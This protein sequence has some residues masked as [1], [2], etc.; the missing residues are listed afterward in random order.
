MG[1][2]FFI[3]GLVVGS[4]LNCV[5]YRMERSQGFLFGRSFCPHCK[6]EL[7]FFDLIPILSF[8]ILR[9]RCRYC[10][11]KISPQYP[12]VELS[13]GILFFLA[14]FKFFHQSL[15][16]TLFYL[17]LFSFFVLIFVFDLQH[18][19]IPDPILFPP[20][21]FSAI[22]KASRFSFQEIIEFFLPFLPSLFFLFFIL[23]SKETWFGWG[24]FWFSI[25]MAEVLDFK[26]LL[27]ALF[28]AFLLGGVIS[29]F[30]LILKK[31]GLK[32]RL[33]F[34]PFLILGTLFAILK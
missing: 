10:Q 18:Y 13:T 11:K 2:L 25:L 27:L 19:A 16:F 32:S 14:Y 12:L 15:F 24:D 26:L 33:P 21:F 28:V 30:L 9:G 6:K 22:Y 31:R 20:I 17:L 4:F 29:I 34:C 8:L 7:S 23:L 3:L 5:I 1:I